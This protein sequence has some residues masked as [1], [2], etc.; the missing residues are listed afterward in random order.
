MRMLFIFGK[1]RTK[2]I[3]WITL[4][5]RYS[6]A[7][8][9]VS[10]CES[11]FKLKRSV[12]MA[13]MVTTLGKLFY[14]L[15]QRLLDPFS[16]YFCA[17]TNQNSRNLQVAQRSKLLVAKSPGIRFFQIP[18][19][20]HYWFVVVVSLTYYLQFCVLSDSNPHDTVN[21]DQNQGD[22]PAKREKPLHGD[23]VPHEN[24]NESQ[25]EMQSFA[26]HPHVV[27][28]HKVLED[29]VQC[30]TPELKQRDSL[31]LMLI[32]CVKRGSIWGL[33]WIHLILV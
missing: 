25:V 6:S 22:Y 12:Q 2:G 29:N 31:W 5:A 9:L 14:H 3:Y 23:L 11:A 17:K 27:C 32:V 33:M 10:R 28:H 18:C 15:L 26:E 20:V 4:A 13:F 16:I 8:F 30:L 24:H 21:W 19:I 7:K 1:L